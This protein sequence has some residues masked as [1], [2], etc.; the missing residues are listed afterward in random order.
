MNTYV[1]LQIKDKGGGAGGVSRQNQVIFLYTT[2]KAL[3][4]ITFLP[5]LPISYYV[6]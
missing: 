5:L 6:F 4:L 3:S 2:D 1:N